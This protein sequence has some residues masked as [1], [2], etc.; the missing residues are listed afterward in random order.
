M[1]KITALGK[2]TDI[3]QIIT[4]DSQ[5]QAKIPHGVKESHK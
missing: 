3:P 1:A 5:L 4:N 2:L